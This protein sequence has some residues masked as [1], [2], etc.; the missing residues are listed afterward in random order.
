MS[1][2]ND[3]VHFSLTVCWYPQVS[4]VTRVDWTL[5]SVGEWTE[6]GESLT[7]KPAGQG[8]A[9]RSQAGLVGAARHVTSQ[10][11][12][13]VQPGPVSWHGLDFRNN[14]ETEYV[15]FVIDD[16]EIEKPEIFLSLKASLA[17]A[18]PV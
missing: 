7:I 1:L 4:R 11:T 18:A 14:A 12:C 16:Y 15:F 13:T 17:P 5:D 6:G 10:Y 2:L 3:T 9:R 8:A